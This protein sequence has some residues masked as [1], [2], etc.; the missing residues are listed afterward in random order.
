M[1][2]HLLTDRPAI[3]R[4]EAAILERDDHGVVAP[5]DATAV[6]LVQGL[7]RVVGGVGGGAHRARIAESSAEY[8]GTSLDVHLAPAAGVLERLAVGIERLTDRAAPAPREP[9]PAI[10]LP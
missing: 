8:P 2:G 10:P 3:G 4:G 6:L 5:L 9:L 7:E 1:V